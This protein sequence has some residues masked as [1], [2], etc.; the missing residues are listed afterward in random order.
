[1]LAVGCS[2]ELNSWQINVYHHT[3]AKSFKSNIT[4]KLHIDYHIAFNGLTQPGIPKE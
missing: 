3:E 2:T 1:M 4:V